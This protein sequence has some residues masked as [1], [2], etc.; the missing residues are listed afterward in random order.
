[1]FERFTEDARQVVILAQGEVRALRHPYIGTEHLLLGLL[2]E[3]NA[4]LAGLDVTYAAARSTMERIVGPG[5]EAPTGQIP[6]TPRAKKVLEFA[7]RESLRLGDSGIR[8]DHILLGI[9]RENDGV[10]ARVLHELGAAPETIWNA[11]DVSPP[12]PD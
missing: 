5:D 1:M 8:A 6:F 4:V 11:L 7:L 9:V 2:R 12:P 10:G 3:N